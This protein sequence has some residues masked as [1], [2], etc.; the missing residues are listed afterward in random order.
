MLIN[1]IMPP[2]SSVIEKSD[3]EIAVCGCVM[4]CNGYTPS[5]TPVLFGLNPEDGSVKWAKSYNTEAGL[6]LLGIKLGGALSLVETQNNDLAF[7]GI[8]VGNIIME[9]GMDLDFTIFKS[10]LIGETCIGS[11]TIVNSES[12]TVTP[13]TPPEINEDNDSTLSFKREITNDITATPAGTE[14]IICPDCD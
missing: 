1:G 9:Y 11:D 2:W 3:G 13:S 7:A 8:Q 12:V 4:T 10:D 5:A 14:K 6:P